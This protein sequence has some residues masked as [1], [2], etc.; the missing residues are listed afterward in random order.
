MKYRY[1]IL[2]GILILVL[3]GFMIYASNKIEVS[4]FEQTTVR[5]ANLGSFYICGIHF[6]P[7]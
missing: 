4:C 5:E 3:G 2:V 6:P 7:K 1:W